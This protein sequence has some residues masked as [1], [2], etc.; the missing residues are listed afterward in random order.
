VQHIGIDIIETSRIRDAVTRWGDTF[1]RRIYTEA[2]YKCYRG[3]LPSLAARF[4]T[5]EAVIKALGVKGKGIGYRNIEV[6][7]DAGGKPQLI[8][9]GQAKKYANALGLADIAISLSH[10]REYAVA[11]ASGQSIH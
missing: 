7:A 6:L 4:A 1:L 9:H 8:L 11:C 10:C 3:R 2:E 5:K